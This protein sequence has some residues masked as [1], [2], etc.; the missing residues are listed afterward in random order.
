MDP[1][2]CKENQLCQSLDWPGRVAASL[3]ESS[4]QGTSYGR[5]PNAQAPRGVK[6][7]LAILMTVEVKF[8][9]VPSEDLS[10]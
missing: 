10:L 4:S 5:S 1:E 6:D 8:S 2:D 9:Q 3:Q 7:G